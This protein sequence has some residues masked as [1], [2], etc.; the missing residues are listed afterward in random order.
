MSSNLKPDFEATFKITNEAL[1][2][3]YRQYSASANTFVLWSGYGLHMIPLDG[4]P[5][6]TVA[7]S[8]S[9]P[10]QTPA[11]YGSDLYA[12]VAKTM[13]KFS[14]HPASA[15]ATTG[16]APPAGPPQNDQ[17]W[18]QVVP[19]AR[20]TGLNVVAWAN[21][22]NATRIL[23]H[24]SDLYD[25]TN[26]IRV[27]EFPG[28]APQFALN[29]YGVQTGTV[30]ATTARETSFELSG[31]GPGTMPAMCAAPYL[32]A[33]DTIL[34]TT[35]DRSRTVRVQRYTLPAYSDNTTWPQYWAADYTATLAMQ[36]PPGG[37]AWD[38][39]A[40]GDDDWKMYRSASGWLPY[41]LVQWIQVL[42]V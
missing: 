16:V 38:P 36:Q 5:I 34:L 29:M 24:R 11:M 14:L 15:T 20:P 9:A 12:V 42:H 2:F 10:I 32:L 6:A 39:N 21:D 41:P 19:D 3:A 22:G 13:S 17:P 26:R 40:I 27:I 7:G 4:T 18:T 30:P 8:Y 1:P 25:F 35:I 31:Y 33:P 23:I 28:A 37:A